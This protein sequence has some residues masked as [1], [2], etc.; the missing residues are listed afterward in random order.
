MVKS[1]W[2]ELI[3]E[4]QIEIN[5][6]VSLCAALYDDNEMTLLTQPCFMEKSA[7]KEYPMVIVTLKKEETLWDLAKRYKT[8][9]D[10]IRDANQLEEEPAAGKRLLIIK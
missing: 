3:N 4:K 1:A 6:T 9:Q 5:C 10:H 7:E 2:V 8:T